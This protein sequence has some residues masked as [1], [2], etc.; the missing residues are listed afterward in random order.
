MDPFFEYHAFTERLIGILGVSRPMMHVHAG[1]AIYITAQLVLRDRRA[2]GLG[3][4]WVAFAE[5]VNETI[6]YGYY[7]SWRWADTGAD[8]LVT[9]FWPAVIVAVGRY[10]R[11]RWPDSS[12]QTRGSMAPPRLAAAILPAKHIH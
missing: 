2:S 5:L 12:A 3:L 6:Q 7:N 8:I 11:R 9:L 10:R 1:L 4:A